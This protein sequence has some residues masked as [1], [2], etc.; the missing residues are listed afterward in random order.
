[1]ATSEFKYHRLYEQ[2]KEDTTYYLLTKE[3]VS[4]SFFE[5]K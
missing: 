2:D 1:M 4:T 5:G 3:Y